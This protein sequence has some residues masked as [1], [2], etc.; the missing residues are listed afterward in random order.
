MAD[1]DMDISEELKGASE[2][3]R[4]EIVR[5]FVEKSVKKILGMK[6]SE[7]IDSNKGF[8][9]LGL[10]SVAAV[11]LSKMVNEGLSGLLE[12]VSTDIFDEPSIN[13]LSHFIDSK[14]PSLKTGQEASHPA[15]KGTKDN[16]TIS[17][18]D[19]FKELDKHLDGES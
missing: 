15:S 17:D 13:K 1:E 2:K 16:P 19:L 18:E 8:A 4:K 3:N 6:Q 10:D 9:D 12:I 7:R 14:L 11:Q 5:S